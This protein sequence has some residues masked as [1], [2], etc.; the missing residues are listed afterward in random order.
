MLA[1]DVEAFLVSYLS[2]LQPPGQVSIQMPA[3]PPMP[4]V[5][6]NRLS[7]GDDYVT[8]SATVS[9]HVF[10]STRSLAAYEARRMHQL[11]KDLL[12]RHPVLLP[13]GTYGAVD[14]VYVV[15]SPAWQEYE[16]KTIWRYCGRYKV[17]LRLQS[18]YAP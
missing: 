18:S 14:Y 15:E 5:L 3:N 12:P 11:M 13:D 9:I 6:I 17:D 2:R 8:D 4:F 10:N 7:G 1:P 16:D